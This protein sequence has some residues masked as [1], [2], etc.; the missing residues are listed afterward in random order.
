MRQSAGGL[1]KSF[2]RISSGF[3]H[4]E[5]GPVPEKSRSSAEHIARLIKHDLSV[6]GDLKDFFEVRSYCW[7]AKRISTYRPG[8]HGLKS[9]RLFNERQSG[10]VRHDVVS[11]LKHV[12]RHFCLTKV[13]RW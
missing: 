10:E 5:C 4:F 7:P 11:V 13:I 1:A 6:I 8:D 9:R 3:S 2:L 12:S